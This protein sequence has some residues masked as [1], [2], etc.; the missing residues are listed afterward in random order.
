MIV[1]VS[2]YGGFVCDTKVFGISYLHQT[3]LLFV[4]SSAAICRISVLRNH[5][6]VSVGDPTMHCSNYCMDLSLEGLKMTQVESKH[7]ALRM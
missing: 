1:F 5:F 6:I 3:Q 7:V 4:T 2:P